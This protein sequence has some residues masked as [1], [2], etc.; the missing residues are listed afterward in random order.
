MAKRGFICGTETFK[1]GDPPPAGYMA[2]H[3]WARVQHKAG[4]RQSRCSKCLRWFFP[5]ERHD[6]AACPPPRRSKGGVSDG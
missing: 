1:P 3:E 4:H 2:W 6:M 5:A